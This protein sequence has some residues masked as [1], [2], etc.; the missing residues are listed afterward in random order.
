MIK[1]FFQNS[2]ILHFLG[3]ISEI[4]LSQKSSLYLSCQI[5]VA[6]FGQKFTIFGLKVTISGQN[7]GQVTNSEKKSSHF[8]MLIKGSF[9]T[10][11]VPSNK[12]FDILKSKS[13]F[14]G[15]YFRLNT[16]LKSC[17]L[18]VAAQSTFL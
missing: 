11:K 18:K 12:S 16:K 6:I 4:Y 8:A 3:V 10:K 13:V 15:D 1:K 9:M 2:K 7:F 17:G 14:Y 5:K